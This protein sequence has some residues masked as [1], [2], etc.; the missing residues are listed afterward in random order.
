MSDM[1]APG[2]DSLGAEAFQAHSGAHCL[3]SPSNISLLKAALRK[4]AIPE[5][6]GGWLL[7]LWKDQGNASS[8][9]NQPGHPFLA[10][11]RTVSM[12]GPWSTD[13][14]RRH[15]Q[16]WK[17]CGSQCQHAWDPTQI[18]GCSTTLNDQSS[19]LLVTFGVG[20]TD[21]GRRDMQSFAT[22]PEGLITDLR[23]IR[24]DYEQR[25]SFEAHVVVPQPNLNIA[26]SHLII[27][28]VGIRHQGPHDGSKVVLILQSCPG[29]AAKIKLPYVA[30][31]PPRTT[32]G[33]IVNALDFAN[34]VYPR[35]ARD[36]F[37]HVRGLVLPYGQ[38]CEFANGD[39]CDVHVGA[40][41][42]HVSRTIVVAQRCAILHWGEGCYGSQWACPGSLQVP[43]GLSQPAQYAFVFAEDSISVARTSLSAWN[44]IIAYSA[45]AQICVILMRQAVVA[46]SVP[47]H[48]TDTDLLA[49]LPRRI[50]WTSRDL[51]QQI[52]RHGAGLTT[53]FAQAMSLT[54]DCAFRPA[55]ICFAF[56]LR[57]THCCTKE[58]T[59]KMFLRK[60]SVSCRLTNTYRATWALCW[61]M[62]ASGPQRPWYDGPK[63]EG[64]TIPRTEDN[65]DLR[66]DG[67]P[68]C[69]LMPWL[70]ARWPVARSL[71]F[72]GS[73]AYSQACQRPLI[74]KLTISS[75]L[76]RVSDAYRKATPFYSTATK[77]TFLAS[78]NDCVILQQLKQPWIRLNT[79]FTCVP[80]THPMVPYALQSTPVCQLNANSLCIYTDCS[81]KPELWRHGCRS[82][83]SMGFGNCCRIQQV[84]QNR[85]QHSSSQWRH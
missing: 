22:S 74:A 29:D 83:C 31:F 72:A 41:L 56:C 38:A 63:N 34:D 54:S 69:I 73:A 49:I 82:F 64:F 36:Y 33:G 11:P 42:Q 65:S 77:T 59:P 43:R 9:A 50:F 58:S 3:I 48:V 40:Y 80:D 7:S 16:R 27:F 25:R 24:Q 55:K 81:F 71:V 4:Q 44:L 52:H 85:L 23:R 57:S 75:S 68:L 53:M 66:Q 84:L 47:D 15:G 30:R 10:R 19:V 70:C 2:I 26:R 37:I 5:F 60:P 79:D 32:P 8:M 51:A 46:L 13:G 78:W 17:P 6:G 1:K 61:N 14:R 20:L 45:P 28:A 35:G 18:W 39:L 67:G 76:L 62:Q 12:G 21:L